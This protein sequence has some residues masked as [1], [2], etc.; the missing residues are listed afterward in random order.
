MKIE[1]RMAIVETKIT[2]M[3]RIL[4]ILVSATLAQVGIQVI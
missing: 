3:Q 2:G 1:E 4:W